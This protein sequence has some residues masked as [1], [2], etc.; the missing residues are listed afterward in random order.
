MPSKEEIE[1]RV[2]EFYGYAIIQARSTFK[3][4]A[5]GIIELDDAEAAALLGLLK[6]AIRYEEGFGATFKTYAYIRIRG[7]LRDLYRSPICD[8]SKALKRITMRTI[9]INYEYDEQVGSDNPLLTALLKYED[10]N[11]STAENIEHAY[12]CISKLP[13]KYRRI[14]ELLAEG[15]NIREVGEEFNRS[16]AWASLRVRETRE[17]LQDYWYR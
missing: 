2:E 5:V 8:Y 10:T 16:A 7:E 3:R 9:S 6:A 13:G 11:A 12:H 1:E 17:L 15:K 14:A 4:S